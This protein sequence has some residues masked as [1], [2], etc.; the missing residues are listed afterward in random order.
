[1]VAE[2]DTAGVGASGAAPAGAERTVHSGRVDGA[3]GPCPPVGVRWRADVR[4]SGRRRPRA[5]LRKSV[6][7]A[8]EGLCLFEQRLPRCSIRPSLLARAGWGDLPGELHRE[9]L[10]LVPLCDATAARGV[11][12]EMRDE[13]DDV[14]GAW[15][16]RATVEDERR[17]LR[18]ALDQDPF[19][20][21]F[22]PLLV[23][24]FEGSHAHHL[25]SLGLW[26]L[27]LLVAEGPDINGISWQKFEGYPSQSPLMVA[28]RAWRPVG[29]GADG[30][31]EWAYALGDEEVARAVRAAVAMGAD[32]NRRLFQAWPLMTYCAWRGCAEAV[33]ACLAAGAEVDAPGGD[34][35]G[36]ETALVHAG[37]EGHEAVVEALLEAGASAEVGEDDEDET[38]PAVCDGHPTPG[39][40]RR[41]V[42]AGA[43]VNARCY[44]HPA[45]N[46]AAKFGNMAV[47]EALVEL[48]A[49]VDGTDVLGR[50]AMHWAASGE[51]VRWLVALG[52]SVQGDGGYESPLYRACYDG[53]VDAVR[54]LIELGADVDVN[55]PSMHGSAP[56]NVAVGF[57]TKQV[58]VEM[59]RLL[60]AAGA[61]ANA[62]DKHGYAPLDN[63]THKACRALLI[64]AGARPRTRGQDID[65]DVSIPSYGSSFSEGPWGWF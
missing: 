27:A 48:G 6:R 55:C 15:G 41:L 2:K 37:R 7:R 18:Q 46:N 11:S 4:L 39:I 30:K 20:V 52:L 17:K 53:R 60:L 42:E 65:S 54:T 56:I 24:A 12:R 44:G 59:T 21:G 36:W 58:A 62:A 3:R 16:I 1:M 14:W 51:V 50:T 64:D 40:V 25:A 23:L 32:V 47:M 38:L 28:V 57:A 45:L 31:V 63:A 43:D 22:G 10:R 29:R 33:K 49:D 19:E 34:I 35:D 5:R 13:V 8:E 61:D 26:W 9:I